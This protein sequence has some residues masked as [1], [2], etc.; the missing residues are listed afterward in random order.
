MLIDVQSESNVCR[1]TVPAVIDFVIRDVIPKRLSGGNSRPDVCLLNVDRPVHHFE[2]LFQRGS[3]A[4]SNVLDCYANW[5]QEWAPTESFDADGHTKS[6]WSL[7]STSDPGESAKVL[8]QAVKEKFSNRSNSQT[9]GKVI[10]LDSLS[11]AL[12]FSRSLDFLLHI[13]DGFSVFSTVDGHATLPCTLVATI[14]RNILEPTLFDGIRRLASTFVLVHRISKQQNAAPPVHRINQEFYRIEVGK[15][16]SSGRMQ[17]GEHFFEMDLNNVQLSPV[18]SDLR[19]ILSKRPYVKGDNKNDDDLELA[20]HGLSFRV[21]LTSKER[22]VRAAASLPY[23]HKNEELADS[24]LAIHPEN[25]RVRKNGAP[26]T[27]ESSSDSSLVG[28]D[29]EDMFSEDV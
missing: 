28:S 16:K 21:T 22:E 9:Q 13:L 7:A 17:F 15:R 3:V 4:S 1:D 10:I 12:T 24:A 27:E 29:G 8:V 18:S 19:V 20:Q 5:Y 2:N 26:E 11:S 23:L 14:Q 25:L 6:P